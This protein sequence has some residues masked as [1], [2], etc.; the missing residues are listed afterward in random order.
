MKKR[1]SKLIR[2][3]VFFVLFPFAFIAGPGYV[4]CQ[5][6]NPDDGVDLFGVPRDSTGST[7]AGKDQVLVSCL[8][9][10]CSMTDSIQ[11]HPLRNE[12]SQLFIQD[13]ILSVALRC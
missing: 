5:D 8:S 2:V 13:L 3:L 10:L 11:H 6:L 1:K 7:T 9:N 12:H 4:D